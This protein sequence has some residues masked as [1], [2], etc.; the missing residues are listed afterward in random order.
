M[1]E[2]LEDTEVAWLLG[3]ASG[4]TFKHRREHRKLSERLR[5]SDADSDRVL[6]YIANR[7]RSI[8]FGERVAGVLSAELERRG[9]LDL[10]E[11]ST[12]GRT[13]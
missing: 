13:N 5:T 9:R 8:A 2:E 12:R 11:R 10:I 7:L 4:R 6:E 1:F 3:L